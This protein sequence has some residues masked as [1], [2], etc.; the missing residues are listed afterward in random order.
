M[1]RIDRLD[2]ELKQVLRTASV[3]GRAF[4]Y[5]LLKAVAEAVRELDDR[6]ERLKAME[7]IR[8]KQKIPELEYIFKHALVQE[9]TYES[10]LLKRRH[11]LHG[12]VASAIEHSSPRGWRSSAASSPITTPRQKT[13]R[14]LRSTSS[15]QATRQAESPQMPRRFPTIS[16]PLRPM[17][18]SSGINGI[19]SRGPP[20]SRKMGEAFYRRGEHEKA[21]EYFRH[22]LALL[23][24]PFPEGTRGVRLAIVREIAVQI[25]H[26]LMPGLFVKKGHGPASPLAEEEAHVYETLCWITG[27]GDPEVFLL[28]SLRLLNLSEGNAIH[29]DTVKGFAG[30]PE[31]RRSFWAF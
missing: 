11:E 29:L 27:V 15:R 10:I 17:P 24:R 26:R 20:S 4:L 31:P 7:L 12:K 9:S 1:A 23:G 28:A 16:K 2:E 19:P 14:R 5:R 3:I 18:G 25:G 21:M 13:G 8:E 22:A 6:V 30:H